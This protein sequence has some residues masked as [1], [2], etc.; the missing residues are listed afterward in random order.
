[1][2]N[3][4]TISLVVLTYQRLES[5]VQLATHLGQVA[6]SLHEIIVVD[7]GA[8]D[9]TREA[10]REFQYVTY[11][12][13]EENMGACGRN[14][15]ILLASGDIVVTLDDDIFGLTTADIDLIRNAF[16]SDPA[17][18]ALNFRVIDYYTSRLTNWVHHRP[19]EDSSQTFDTYEITEGAVAFS[20]RAVERIGGYWAPYFIS[21]EGPD[22]AF[23]LMNLGLVVRYDGRIVV[24]HK[25]EQQGRPGWRFYYYD[26]RNLIWLAIRNMDFRY[27]FTF[28]TVQLSAMA[29]YSLMTGHLLW[30]FRAVGDGVKE[31]RMVAATRERWTP[32]TAARVTRIDRAR[33]PFFTRVWQKLRGSSSRLDG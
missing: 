6:S 24:K 25:H 22:L 29:Y 8:D 2:N 3:D 23:R 1:M 4:L 10:M 11:L 12:R 18:G 17:L 20:R 9:H 15:G 21:H 16:G 28:L 13:N 33:I 14:S 31:W 19:V 30:W 26:T 27:A 7:N 5:V 32:D